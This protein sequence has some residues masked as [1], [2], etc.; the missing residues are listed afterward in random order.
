MLSRIKKIIHHP[1]FFPVATT[2]IF[3]VT[4]LILVF[5]HEAWR[6]EA[7]VWQGAKN[8][9]FSNFYE[10]FKVEPHPPLWFILLAPFA[11]LGL[12]LI[13]SSFLSLAVV[14]AAVYLL[15]RFSPFS[16]KV[17]TIFILS[18]AFFYILPVMGR[19]YSL[20]PLALALLAV[21]YKNRLKH[22]IKFALG[23]ALLFQSHFLLAG[24]AGILTIFFIYDIIKSK[25]GKKCLLPIILIV[26]ASVILSLPMIIGT[27]F[28][29]TIV[30][31]TAKHGIGST[32]WLLNINQSLF[33][34]SLPIFELLI[35]PIFILLLFKSP[36]A[37]I[38][39]LVAVA[40]HLLIIIF[41][42]DTGILQ[43]QKN[44]FIL[45]YIIFAFWI[46]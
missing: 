30:L 26:S 21:L 41:A 18:A 27:L 4:N 6:D 31:E 13:F 44:T 39:L 9:S 35:L 5:H 37:F 45:L 34:S 20:V 2:I 38:Y 17:S 10:T 22:P 7:N 12:P 28:E 14:A 29:H 8:L 43:T 23:L 40:S 42:Y 33:A 24:L 19:N 15:A 16:K 25:Q 46:Y 36:R 1:L 32:D 11:K 3:F